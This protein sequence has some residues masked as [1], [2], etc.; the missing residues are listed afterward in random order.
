MGRRLRTT[1]H[2]KIARSARRRPAAIAGARPPGRRRDWAPAPIPIAAAGH[3][4]AA[5]RRQ[6]V[7]FSPGGYGSGRPYASF[8]SYFARSTR[9]HIVCILMV[10]RQDGLPISRDDRSSRE[11][12]LVASAWGK[13]Q[14]WR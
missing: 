9:G 7:R 4:P 10:E 14:E 13:A 11:L 12:Q 1:R 2:F 8:R 3:H 6:P 5:W